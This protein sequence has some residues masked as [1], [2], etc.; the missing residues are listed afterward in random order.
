MRLISTTSKDV[1]LSSDPNTDAEID[2]KDM[3]CCTTS[4]D[5]DHNNNLQDEDTIITP[6][7]AIRSTRQ[8]CF[9]GLLST[10]L[11]I[12]I[13]PGSLLL[14]VCMM[15]GSVCNIYGQL[16]N[17][18]NPQAA[19]IVGLLLIG[20]AAFLLC[21]PFAIMI[22]GC[23]RRNPTQTIR[24]F[25]IVLGMWAAAITG[26]FVGIYSCIALLGLGFGQLPWALLFG[27]PSSL[28]T[29]LLLACR[30][31]TL[32]I[33]NML[34]R[35][36]AMQL[37]VLLLVVGPPFGIILFFSEEEQD[38]V[39]TAELDLFIG[40]IFWQFLFLTTSTMTWFNLWGW[41]QIDFFLAC[42][43]TITVWPFLMHWLYQK[44][45]S[46]VDWLVVTHGQYHPMVRLL[47]PN[48][49]IVNGTEEDVVSANKTTEFV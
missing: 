12:T 45:V 30:R 11:Y 36:D 3:S 27:V 39:R 23:C 44:S 42:L 22:I 25:S 14:G 5:I 33:Q 29:C 6:D 16:G 48:L 19:N 24:G 18:L 43:A 28:L 17:G 8:K 1:G 13:A 38:T 2:A 10:I 35:L 31:K 47:V 26:S 41:I 32:L 9:V 37:A 20:I 46:F 40:T 49:E 7:P 4:T 15:S 34:H 21:L